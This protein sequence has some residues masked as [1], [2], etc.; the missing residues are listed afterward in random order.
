MTYKKF[1]NLGPEDMPLGY[2]P[3]EH[4]MPIGYP[5]RTDKM[6]MFLIC[7]AA[8]NKCGSVEPNETSPRKE[9]RIL[10]H[11]ERVERESA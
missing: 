4:G 9:E 3:T 6:I 1:F 7:K 2:V 10:A 8:I 11:M 5:T